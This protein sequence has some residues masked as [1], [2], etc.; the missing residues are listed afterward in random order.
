MAAI[1]PQGR[2]P[3]IPPAAFGKVFTW[4]GQGYG[5][6]RIA[7]FLGKEGIAASKSSVFRLLHGL[8]PYHEILGEGV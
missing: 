6:R 4:H 7:Y 8:A 5:E 3:A 1:G 2:R